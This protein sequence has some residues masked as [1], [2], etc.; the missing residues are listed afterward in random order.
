MAARHADRRRS[1]RSVSLFD[2]PSLME[3]SRRQSA[4]TG[5]LRPSLDSQAVGGV[6]RRGEAGG[7]RASNGTCL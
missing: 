7:H 6:G 5:R 4:L 1:T 2:N 3:Q